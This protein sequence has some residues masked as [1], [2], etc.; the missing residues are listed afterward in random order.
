[1]KKFFLQFSLFLCAGLF[2]WQ[3]G[4][5]QVWGNG[6][7]EEQS[8]TISPFHSIVSS[9][10][11]DVEAKQGSAFSLVV[12][13]D[14]NLIPYIKTEVKNNVLYVSATKNIWK[15]R[16]MKVMVTMKDLQKVTLAGSG[17]FSCKTP[18]KSSDV[19]FVVMGSGD[20]EA[21][22]DARNAGVKI[23]GSGDVKLN[24]V[25]GSLTAE[26]IGSG[27]LEASGL[28]LENCSLKLAGSGDMELK[29]RTALLTV[30]SLGSGDV[31]GSGLT[32]VRVKVKDNGS[33]DVSVH[34]VDSLEA[35]MAGSGDLHYSGNPTVL[36]VSALGSGAVY[37][38]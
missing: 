31:D 4:F 12:Y 18:F 11:V 29:G 23:S 16:K 36:K 15:A 17:D 35:T 19:Q 1:M 20:V 21:A 34:A 33:G 25:R 28:Q 6:V 5:A 8:R 3:P 14:G 30:M 38:R 7:V 2:L 27:D 10:P 24:G 37:R 9:G 13:A 32:A 22:L 26:V